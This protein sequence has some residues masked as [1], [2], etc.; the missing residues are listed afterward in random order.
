MEL[1]S[2]LFSKAEPSLLL[3]LL[4]CAANC[5]NGFAILLLSTPVAWRFICGETYLRC[6]SPKGFE[7]KH[8]RAIFLIW[9]SLVY[10]GRSGQ[11]ITQHRGE[12][13]RVYLVPWAAVS[14]YSQNAKVIT[15]VRA[16]KRDPCAARWPE[17]PRECH[18][19]SVALCATYHM[20]PPSPVPI[21]SFIQSVKDWQGVG[22]WLRIVALLGLRTSCLQE[23]Q[24][25]KHKLNILLESCT[26]IVYIHLSVDSSAGVVCLGTQSY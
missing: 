17:G 21:Q 24:S 26:N 5:W 16:A 22:L 15:T 23:R 9:N 10:S 11:V 4:L 7:K 12:S 20:N 6:I 3:L 19:S 1:K 18:A 13:F 2:P 25:D 8:T 14:K